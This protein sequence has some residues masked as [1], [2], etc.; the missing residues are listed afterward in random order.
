MEALI[1]LLFGLFA[2]IFYLTQKRK[3]HLEVE[4]KYLAEL[5]ASE[6]QL[7]NERQRR[8]TAAI[9]GQEIERNRIAR[10]LHDGIGQYL[11]AIKVKLQSLLSDESKP[12]S[13]NVESINQL[14]G[15]AV[16]EVKRISENL[17]PRMLDEFGLVVALRRLCDDATNASNIEVDFVSFGVDANAEKK[18]KTHLY[19]IVQEALSNA[20]KHSKANHVDIQLLGNPQQLTL[21]VQD[22]GVGFHPDAEEFS[23]G[24][25]L[26]NIVD[27]VRVMEGELEIISSPGNGTGIRVKVQS[28]SWTDNE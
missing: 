20:L 13:E 21:L 9:D 7:K 17:M 4:A 10:E 25:G 19:R 2:Y 28:D 18:F 3:A 11:V 27:R 23:H 14:T 24:N 1:L 22:D 16:E 8:L 12:E 5:A 26:K 15:I 6:E